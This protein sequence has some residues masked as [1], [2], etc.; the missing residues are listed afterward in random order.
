[1][2][3]ALHSVK[4]AYKEQVNVIFSAE[5]RQRNLDPGAGGEAEFGG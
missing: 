5:I 1:M 3:A 2:A 4:F